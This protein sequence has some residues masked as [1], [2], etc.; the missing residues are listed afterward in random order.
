[1]KNRSI[2]TIFAFLAVILLAFGCIK[3]SEEVI[4]TDQEVFFQVTYINYAFGK[5]AS[6]FFIDKTGAVKTYQGEAKWDSEALKGQLSDLQM[7]E[8]LALATITK[9]QLM[10][11]ELKKYT[12]T[13]SNISTDKFSKRISG[14]ADRGSFMYYAYTFNSAE[15]IYK[16][17]KLAEDG[18]WVSNNED[19]NAQIIVDW[20]KDIQENVF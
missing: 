9:K 13:I 11:D 4:N 14:G 19:A 15:N 10:L 2:I 1:M 5:Q 12:Q 17:V 8:N 18:D 20:L 16:A 3:D 6:G 7:K